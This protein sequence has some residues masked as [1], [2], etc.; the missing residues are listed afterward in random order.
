MQADRAF[1][2]DGRDLDGTAVSR[3]HHQGD[4]SALR[5]IDFIERRAGLEQRLA[6]SQRDLPQVAAHRGKGV[7][8]QGG[9]QPVVLVTL[10]QNLG[11]LSS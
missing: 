6:L 11:Q 9:E 7:L 8:R 1:A 3:H 2:A 4:H 5:K 10:R